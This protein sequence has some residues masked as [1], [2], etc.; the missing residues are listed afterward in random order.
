MKNKSQDNE[1]ERSQSGIVKI[2]S[3]GS[4]D[5]FWLLENIAVASPNVRDYFRANALQ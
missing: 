4:A 1:P 3:G 5:Q 2:K